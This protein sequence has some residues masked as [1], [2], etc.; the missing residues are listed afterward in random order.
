[1]TP[2]EPPTYSELPV[3]YDETHRGR[4]D[5]KLEVASMGNA[6]S[7]VGFLEHHDA[8][9][10]DGSF[11]ICVAGGFGTFVNKVFAKKNAS[12]EIPQY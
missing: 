2:S 4:W 6:T 7:F 12:K 8:P 9:S 10:T 11:A 3:L 1:M 5:G